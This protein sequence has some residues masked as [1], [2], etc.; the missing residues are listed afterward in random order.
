[1]SCGNGSQDIKVTLTVDHAHIIIDND[2]TSVE[3]TET[4]T[5][6]LAGV[7]NNTGGFGVGAKTDYTIKPNETLTL[8][9]VNYSNRI[10]NWNNWVLEMQQGTNY[11]DLRADKAGWGAF[12]NEANCQTTSY[13]DWDVF[14]EEMDG[15]S[16]V[17]TIARSGADINI[18]AQMTSVA[19]REFKETYTFSNAVATD[20]I[21]ARLL[22][23]GAHLDILSDKTTTGI[24]AINAQP[25]MQDAPMFD[26]S[27]RRV[28]A[29]YKG[30]VIQ[31]GKKIILK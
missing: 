9:F 7:E 28:D 30:I 4:V 20:D 5:G 12:W 3:D 14:R 22:T 27:G 13:A 19:G 6:T 18:E 31:N 26:L 15:A 29:Q 24:S 2:A 1:M 10:E 23:E 17:M 8:Q 11:L 21:T 16:V 25:A